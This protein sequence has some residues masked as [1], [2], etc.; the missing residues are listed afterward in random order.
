MRSPKCAQPAK[1]P[2]KT[3]DITGCRLCLSAETEVSCLSPYLLPPGKIS[4]LNSSSEGCAE[5]PSRS[6]Q[7]GSGQRAVKQGF[8]NQSQVKSVASCVGAVERR[9]FAF[10]YSF[11]HNM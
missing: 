9:Y 1:P 8:V 4:L 11:T 10:P 3:E 7:A 5:L 2:Q 6:P